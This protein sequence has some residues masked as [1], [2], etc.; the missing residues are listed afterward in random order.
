MCLGFTVTSPSQPEWADCVISEAAPASD[1]IR[2]LAIYI[3]QGSWP[4]SG[5]DQEQLRRLQFYVFQKGCISNRL[6]D[7]F[8]DSVHNLPSVCCYSLQEHDIWDCYLLECFG[9]IMVGDVVSSEHSSTQLT[10]WYSTR[11]VCSL[12]IGALE[13]EGWALLRMIWMTWVI[14]YTKY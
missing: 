7:R 4:S 2:R 1:L 14:V 11:Q 12:V 8:L 13:E 5:P 10:H 9:H 6:G 3:I